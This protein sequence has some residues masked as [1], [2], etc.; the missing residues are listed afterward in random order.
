[1]IYELFVI[2]ADKQLLNLL[3]YASLYYSTTI[4]LQGVAEFLHLQ[5]DNSR[6]IQSLIS[7]G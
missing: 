6:K 2:S 3:F 5:I 4:Y 1:M 7:T